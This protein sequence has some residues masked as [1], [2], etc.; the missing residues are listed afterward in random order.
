VSGLNTGLDFCVG[1]AFLG[2]CCGYRC[3]HSSLIAIGRHAGDGG[4]RL[5]DLCR[6]RRSTH[7]PLVGWSLNSFP[8]EPVSQAV[9][10]YT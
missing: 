8:K 2:N 10:N 9:L 7:T 3:G 4:V 6:L 5:R 1:P